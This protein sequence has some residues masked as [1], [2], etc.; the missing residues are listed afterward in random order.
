MSAAL[1]N[2]DWVRKLQ[3]PG[4]ENAGARFHELF[5]SIRTNFNTLESQTNSNLQ[6]NPGPPP[7]IDGFTVSPHPSG[8]DISIQHNGEFYR[9]VNY[10]VDYADNPH[11]QGARTQHIGQSR[12]AIIPV[13]PWNGFYQVRASYPTGQSTTPV[14]FGG[15]TPQMVRGGSVSQ[16]NF[17]PSEGAGTTRPGQPPGF[18]SQYRGSVPPK[19]SK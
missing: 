14:I 2:L 11:F 13:G 3:I 16:V 19:R 17:L 18:G 6:G 9:G 15:P 10:E 4:V 1:K 5:D 7:A 12:N 8:V